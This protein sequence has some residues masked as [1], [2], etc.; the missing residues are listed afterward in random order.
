MSVLS[1]SPGVGHLLREWRQR[2]RMSQLDLSV[3]AEVSSRHLSFVETGRSKPSRELIIHLAEHLDVPLRDRNDLLL[4]AGYAP[5]YAETPLEDQAMGP[6]RAALDDLLAAHDPFPAVIVDRA[7]NLVT[8]NRSSIEVLTADVDPALLEPPVNVLKVSLH[9]DGMAPRIANL[10][11]WGSH[12]LTR[13]HRQVLLTADP[14]LEALRAEVADYPGIDPVP[15]AVTDPAAMLYV[16]LQLRSD[17]GLLTFF[18]TIATFGTA[19]DIT[20]AELSIESFYPADAAT[21]EV[22]RRRAAV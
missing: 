21:A 7:W 20:L 10:A 12:L 16:P 15:A 11:E 19:V 1:P 14:R 4:A 13:L 18:S 2:R 17:D 6:V 8:A 5:V 3:E 22:L 9:P